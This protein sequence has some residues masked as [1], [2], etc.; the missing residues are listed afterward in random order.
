MI[1]SYFLRKNIA[2]M[3]I[4]RLIRRMDIFTSPGDLLTMARKYGLRAEA[5]NRGN[6]QEVRLHLAQGRAIQ[7]LIR[8]EDGLHYVVL[9]GI[10]AQELSGEQII[11]LDPAIGKRIF[12]PTGLFLSKWG[13][14]P[15]LFH[16]FFI[17][18]A[19]DSDALPASRINDLRLAIGVLDGITKFANNLH[20]L[21]FPD[22][23]RSRLKSILQLFSGLLQSLVCAPPAL[24]RIAIGSLKAGHF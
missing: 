7:A 17:V 22:H 10:E 18:Y 8:S 4:D 5:Y 24:L 11:C 21:F 9:T 23:A 14:L 19:K 3:D 16:N 1:L 13:Y 15:G 20:F 12:L 2:V 6:L